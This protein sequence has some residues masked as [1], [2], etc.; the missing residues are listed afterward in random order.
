MTRLVQLELACKAGGVALP[1]P[2]SLATAAIA[3]AILMQTSAEQAQSSHRIAPSYLKLV[4][5]SNSW[6]LMLISANTFS[7]SRLGSLVPFSFRQL[8]GI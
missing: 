5:S 4:T 2:G 7:F 3:E 6:P 1:D 8:P